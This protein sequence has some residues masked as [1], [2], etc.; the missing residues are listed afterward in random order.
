MGNTEHSEC[1]PDPYYVTVTIKRGWS[2]DVA[3]ALSRR[4]DLELR[5]A[6]CCLIDDE[7]TES[8]DAGTLIAEMSGETF[9]ISPPTLN[10][11]SGLGESKRKELILAF[12]KY[13]EVLTTPG[14]QSKEVLIGIFDE[15]IRLITEYPDISQ[16]QTMKLRG[17]SLPREDHQAIEAF[18]KNG[19]K[20]KAIKHLRSCTQCGLKEAKDAIEA[21]F[22]S[23]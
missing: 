17:F 19:Q 22:Q 9:D 12:N 11:R 4:S 21:E 2:R 5:D 13:R 10:K 16:D 20:I 7:L 1:I 23:F 15:A 14:V 6:L 3:Q 8:I 18:M